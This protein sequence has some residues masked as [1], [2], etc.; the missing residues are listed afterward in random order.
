MTD[1]IT[2]QNIG[3]SS[4]FPLYICVYIYIYIRPAQ[5]NVWK[6]QTLEI[7]LSCLTIFRNKVQINVGPKQ[8]LQFNY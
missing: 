8:S 6:N 2:S 3:L 1:T 7:T 4:R 5:C